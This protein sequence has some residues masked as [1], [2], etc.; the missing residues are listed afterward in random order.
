MFSSI[1]TAKCQSIHSIKNSIPRKNSLNCFACYRTIGFGLKHTSAIPSS[2]MS[3][4]HKFRYTFNR[5]EYHERARISLYF[6][7]HCYQHRICH[8]AMYVCA[9]AL[10]IVLRFTIRFCFIPTSCNVRLRFRRV[11]CGIMEIMFK[12]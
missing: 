8:C 6:Q 5:K 1:H 3:Q 7:G 10:A 11:R 9:F 12:K 2:G 4:N